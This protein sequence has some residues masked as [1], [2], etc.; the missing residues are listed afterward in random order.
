MFD[1]ASLD[2]AIGL[3][4]LF[5]ILSLIC[6]AINEFV[7]SM[8]RWRAAFLRE[9]IENLL[10]GTDDRANGSEL[11]EQ[12]YHHPLIQ[13]LVKPGWAKRRRWPSY[14]PSRTF[15]AALLGDVADGGAAQTAAAMEDAINRLP[16]AE[17]RRAMTALLNRSQGDLTLFQAR[18]EEWYDDAM[19][20]VSGWYRR[21]IQVALTIIAAALVLALNVDTIQVARHLWSDEAVRKTVV[22]SAGADAQVRREPPDINEVAKTVDELEELEIPMGWSLADDPTPETPNPR[23]LVYP[24]DDWSWFFGKVLGLVLTVAAVTLGAPFWFDVL[25]KVARLRATGAPPPTTDAVRKGEGEEKRAGPTAT[26]AP[27]EPHD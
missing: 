10:S 7:A 27:E 17:V 14:I 11:A 21:R 22:A 25:S 13:G 26:A 19:E 15:V 6:S 18:V 5:F 24:W 12:I 20:R 1:F 3:V 23:R 4:F 2:V 9:G 16:S 8:L